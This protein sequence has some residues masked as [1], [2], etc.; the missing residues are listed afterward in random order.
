M[1]SY[2]RGILDGNTAYETFIERF[3]EEGKAFLDKLGIARIEPND[4]T[5]DPILLGKK[6]KRHADKVILRK[7]GVIPPTNKTGEETK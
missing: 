6:F 5:L 4:V 1:N 7:A 3:G 2:S